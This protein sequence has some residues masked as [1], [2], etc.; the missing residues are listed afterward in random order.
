MNLKATPG[1]SSP[2]YP[3]SPLP[4]PGLTLTTVSN[5]PALQD[6]PEAHH[7]S[8]LTQLL[9]PHYHSTAALFPHHSGHFRLSY[10]QILLTLSPSLP[11][12]NQQH[13]SFAISFPFLRLYCFSPVARTP[14]TSFL[15]S[16]SASYFYLPSPKSLLACP[17]T[18]SPMLPLLCACPHHG[19]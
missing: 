12:I 6:R 13:F 1:A 19:S 16:T 4:F 9:L 3:L 14:L 7:Q 2:T 18:Y 11:F 10:R 17:G 5:S 15:G 8:K